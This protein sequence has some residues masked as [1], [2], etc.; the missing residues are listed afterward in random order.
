MKS[1]QVFKS[2]NINKTKKYELC[3]CKFFLTGNYQV[4]QKSTTNNDLGDNGMLK[5]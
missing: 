4:I 1:I 2:I 5:G 3:L